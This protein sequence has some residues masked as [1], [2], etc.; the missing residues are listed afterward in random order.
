MKKYF[1][2]IKLSFLCT[3]ID[4]VNF[5]NFFASASFFYF[6]EKSNLDAA[7]AAFGVKCFFTHYFGFM[8]ILRSVN[9]G[10]RRYL[11]FPSCERD[12]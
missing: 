2:K 5:L 12:R 7:S 9:L 8:H 10:L 4:M 3:P 1:Y 11:T 6:S